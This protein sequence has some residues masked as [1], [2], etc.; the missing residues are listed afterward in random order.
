MLG[1]SFR[2]RPAAAQNPV[3]LSNTDRAT[4]AYAAML[5]AFAVPGTPHLGEA[6]PR[7]FAKPYAYQWPLSQAI[8]ATLG[9]AGLP[10]IGGDYLPD[11][12]DRVWALAYYWDQSDQPPAFSS[13]V[14]PPYGEGGDVY[15]DDN[16]WT[17][18]QLI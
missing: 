9:M 14:V 1:F 8:S 17:G 15:Y 10:L 7:G 12:R 3:A 11:L 5:R 6:S 13:Y 4:A 18:L 16:A 2:S